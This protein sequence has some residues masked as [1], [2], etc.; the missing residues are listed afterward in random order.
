MEECF[1]S[2]S[3]CAFFCVILRKTFS[4]MVVLTH[5][6]AT[7]YFNNLTLP[8]AFYLADSRRLTRRFSRSV[9]IQRSSAHPSA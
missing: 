8:E 7:S 4:L 3:I 5:H 6:V 9:F 1:Y 2:A